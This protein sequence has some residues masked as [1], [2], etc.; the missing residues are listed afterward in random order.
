MELIS[1][2]GVALPSTSSPKRK[3]AMQRKTFPN[4]LLESTSQWG[5]CPA[6]R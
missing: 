3:L 6:L 4:S 1:E 2:G 5:I